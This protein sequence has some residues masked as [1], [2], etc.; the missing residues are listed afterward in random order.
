MDFLTELV[1]ER[2]PAAFEQ[3]DQLMTYNE[4]VR[5]RSIDVGFLSR[6]DAIAYSMAGPM[7][8]AS[9]VNYDVRRAEPYSYY[10]QLDFDVP[11]FY[12]GDVYDR[13]RVRL[14]EMKQSVR[15]VKQV[16]PHLAATAGGPITSGKPQY[17]IRMPKPGES[18]ARVENPKGELGYYVTAKR[19]SSNPERYHVRATSFIN[20][21]ALEKMCIGY[22]IADVVAIL[23]SIDIVLGEVD[24]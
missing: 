24:R 11:V 1:N 19:R 6:E 10:D 18:Y 9:G 8:R 4:I 5:A 20:L 7:L 22:K 14:E 23:G 15:I 2:L 13:Y 16:L 3:A 21:T 12:N 17:A